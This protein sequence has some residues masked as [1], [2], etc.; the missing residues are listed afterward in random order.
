[1]PLMLFLTLSMLSVVL[2]PL[3]EI[4]VHTL[5]PVVFSKM[6]VL[7]MLM[8]LDTGTVLP[9]HTM[10]LTSVDPLL[11]S[12]DQVFLVPFFNN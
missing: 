2:R 6:P 4:H 3:P 11:K 10:R 5:M 9:T 8:F 7:L 1:M 12:T